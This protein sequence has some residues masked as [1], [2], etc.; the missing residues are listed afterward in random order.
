MSPVRPARAAR[1]WDWW[2][3]VAVS[4][5]LLLDGVMLLFVV[6]TPSVFRGDTGVPLE[7]LRRAYPTVAAEMAHRGRTLALMLVVLG[8]VAGVATVT[9]LARG[10]R[11]ARAVLAWVAIA[12][13]ALGLY[14]VALGRVD[15][16]ALY[17]VTAALGGAGLLR[18]ARLG[19][20]T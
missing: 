8:G 19:T 4:M 11:S 20:R 7:E 17:L 9:G 14:F 18:P 16:A 13:A 5:L 1:R 15:I 2:L 3:W 6:A 10:E 12:L